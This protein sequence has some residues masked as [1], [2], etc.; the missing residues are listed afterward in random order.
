[1]AYIDSTVEVTTT[2]TVH[3]DV[4]GIQNQGTQ[5]MRYTLSSDFA[6]DKKGITLQSG[7]KDTFPKDTVYIKTVSGSTS[8]MIIKDL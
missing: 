5:A 6:V 8:A 1:M 3:T 2:A 4:I 7:E